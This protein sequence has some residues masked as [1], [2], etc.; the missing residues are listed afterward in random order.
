M[1]IIKVDTRGIDAF[2]GKLHKIKKNAI[3]HAAKRSLNDV[4]FLAKKK[5]PEVSEKNMTIRRKSYLASHTIVEKANGYDLNSMRSAV[6][7]DAK[8]KTADSLSKQ[9]TGGRIDKKTFI[10]LNTARVGKNYNKRI[11]RNYH[12]NKIEVG[13]KFFVKESNGKKYLFN[14]GAKKITAIYSF[15]KGR[16]IKLKKNSFIRPSA[17]IAAKEFPKMF[18]KNV[19]HQINKLNK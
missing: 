6:G 2:I 19:E 15:K 8:R 11:K 4:A 17:E 3:P 7:I 13:S 16:S 5:V 1:E 9:E 18:K 14:R 10:P 12:I